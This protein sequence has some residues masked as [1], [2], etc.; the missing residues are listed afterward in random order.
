MRMAP[1]HLICNR[2]NHAAE[3]KKTEFLGDA[4]LKHNLEQQIAQ[5][6]LEIWHI[7]SRDG[8][9]DLV[10]FL[11]REGNDG[12]EGLFQIPVAT[13]SW[14]AQSGHDFKEAINIARRRHAR[15]Q[16]INWTELGAVPSSVQQSLIR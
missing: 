16:C 15:E 7:V 5:F 2:F 4:S 13:A 3:I 1:N 10:G 14:R 12:F 6:I 11:D 9:G 8:V